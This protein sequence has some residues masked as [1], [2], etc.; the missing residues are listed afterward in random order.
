[1]VKI[2][3]TY[4]QCPFDSF[5]KILYALKQEN[6]TIGKRKIITLMKKLNIESIYPKQK[7]FTS[8]STKEHK[9]YLYLL[10]EKETIN[11]PKKVCT[12]D[13]TYLNFK[14]GLV[15]LCS[16][17]DWYTR[18]MSSYKISNTM[19]SKFSSLNIRISM[20]SKSRAYDNIIIERFE[21]RLKYENICLENYNSIKENKEGIREYIDF[22]NNKRP[23]E[24]LNYKTPLNVYMADLNRIA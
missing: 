8:M 10:K 2:A 4:S 13:I 7:K 1:M 19:D 18:A 21:R 15:Y 23:H 5:R 14:G 22:Y 17:I 9:K 16:V 12:S 11:K 3:D 24:S 20:D 6:F